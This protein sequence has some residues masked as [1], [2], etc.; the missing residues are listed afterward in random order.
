M[1]TW[2]EASAPGSLM[3]FGEH[4]VL[5]GRPALVGSVDVRVRAH[6]RLRRDGRLI[7]QSALGRYE[8]PM[9]A[10]TPPP[11]ELRFAVGAVR[12]AAEGVLGGVELD[13]GSDFSPTVGLGSSAAVTVAV[14][15]V[16]TALRGQ[17]LNPEFLLQTGRQVVREAQGG[18]GSGAD[19]AASV[20]GGLCLYH[21][22]DVRPERLPG[23]PPIVLIYA[24]YKTP[25]AEVIHRVES[26]RRADPARYERLFDAAGRLTMAA[27]AA[28]RLGDLSDAGLRMNAAQTV[29]EE[30]GV[31]DSTLAAIVAALR[32]APGVQ[33][34]KISGSGLGDGVIGLGGTAG[35]RGP[36]CRMDVRLAES[37]VRLEAT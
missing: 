29:L 26:A 2:I 13:I 7:L 33:G 21:M 24:G 14:L 27:A 20:F 28:F 6:A 8:A 17:P 1:A 23:I 37:G 32:S 10:K 5:H 16:V 30:L 25:T 36:G 34:A 35:Y 4:A 12:R 9:E 19:V 15:A 22:D 3:L 31:C 18:V 11:R